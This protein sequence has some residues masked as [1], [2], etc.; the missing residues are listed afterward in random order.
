ME[1]LKRILKIAS[2]VIDALNFVLEQIEKSIPTTP[3]LTKDETP[4]KPKE[5]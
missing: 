1:N 5:Q 4:T 3:K 2:I